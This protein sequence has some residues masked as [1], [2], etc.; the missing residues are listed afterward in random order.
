VISSALVV[1][2]T[3]ATFVVDVARTDGWTFGRQNL[4]VLG[5]FTGCG[6]GD[7]LLVPLADS[8]QSFVVSPGR[9][10]R[11]DAAA[12]ELG[13]FTS[14]VIRQNAFPA[15]PIP[16]RLP[17][18]EMDLVGSWVS[19]DG[20]QPEAN[21][22]AL[23]TD[24]YVISSPGA[25]VALM[26]RG[27]FGDEMD[28]GSAIALQWGSQ[29]GSSIDYRGIEFVA[30]NASLADWTMQVSAPPAGADRV[31][32]LLRDGSESAWVAA[33][34]PL[35]VKTAPMSAA[36]ETSPTSGFLVSPVFGMYIPCIEVPRFS[37]TIVGPPGIMVETRLVWQSTFAAAAT[38]DRYFSFDSTGVRPDQHIDSLVVYVSQEYL[39]GSPARATG[40]FQRSSE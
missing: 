4:D 30:S 39:T 2:I 15:D 29:R 35:S 19:L 27:P 24:W 22:G 10:S 36:A 17:L 28:V 14:G 5:G 40:Q 21:S 25:Q 3:A 26:T 34:M 12:S 31:R 37:D 8:L 18:A 38:A 20:A 1:M 11:A 32:M 6:L 16:L 23:I 13:F 9:S 33:S 7:E